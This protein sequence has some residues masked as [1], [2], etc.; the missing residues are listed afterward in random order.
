M[1][2]HTFHGF[3][4]YRIIVGAALLGAK[5]HE[6]IFTGGGTESDNLA[7]KGLYWARRARDV[8]RRRIVTGPAEHAAVR[9]TVL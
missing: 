5:P 3:A 4:I 7:V 8:R 9:N 2:S 1:Q 6:I